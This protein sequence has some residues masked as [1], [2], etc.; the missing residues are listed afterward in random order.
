MRREALLWPLCATKNIRS[1]SVQLFSKCFQSV[2]PENSEGQKDKER[3][4]CKAT[5][6]V[7]NYQLLPFEDS[8]GVLL[9]SVQHLS[10]PQQE[11]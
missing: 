1:R 4:S 5:E 8:L 2:V 10:S 6:S 11:E 9:V 7:A 3:R